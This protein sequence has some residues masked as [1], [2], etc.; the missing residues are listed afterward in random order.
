M[1]LA[2]DIGNTH[3]LGGVFEGAG[4]GASGSSRLLTRFRHATHPMGTADQFGLFLRNILAANN[5][6]HEKIT[7]AALCSVVP[8]VNFTVRHALAQYIGAPVF[9]LKAGVK[10]G[11]NIKYK[12][13]SEVGADRIADA[14]GAAAAFPGRNLVIVD[15]GT[16]TTV[17]VVTKNAD[18]MGGVI[19]PGMRVSM[20]ALKLNTAKLTEVDIEP[21][22][23]RLGQTTRESIQK[24]LYFGQLGALREIVNGLKHEQ[25]GKEE[26]TVIGTGGFSR[27]FRDAGLFDVILPDLVLDGIRIAHERNI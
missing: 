14:I 15:M 18:F 4:P 27:L 21:S 3:I 10:T 26:A 17:G 16:A 12:N 7:H 11:L 5:L 20:E 25:F 22:N 24:G 8:G 19:M 13:P 2:L 9:E 23:T 1:L 6:S